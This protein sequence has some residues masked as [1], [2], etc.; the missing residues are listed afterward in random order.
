[1]TSMKIVQF[2]RLLS[3]CFIYVQNSFTPLTLDVQFQTK[4]SSPTPFSLL[5]LQII[6]NQLKENI[7]QGWLSYVIKSFLQVGFRFQYQPINLV[8]LSFDFFHLAEAP[9][10]YI[11]F[12]V[13]L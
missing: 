4:N 9:H 3:P 1:M 6:T 5:C 10:Y 8:W 12:F 13:A 11:S 7:I 2:S